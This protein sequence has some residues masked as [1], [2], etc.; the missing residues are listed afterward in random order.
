MPTDT[1][2]ALR[3]T[4]L[5]P[6]GSGKTCLINAYVNNTCP[7]VYTPTD[8]PQLYYRTLRTEQEDDDV[9]TTVL[10]E[11]E[12]TYSCDRNDGKDRFGRNRNANQW[13]IMKKPGGGANDPVGTGEPFA[14]L[15][16]PKE[17]TYDPFSKGRMGFILLFDINDESSLESVQ[18][19]FGLFNDRHKPK[20]G[21]NNEPIVYVVANKIDQDPLGE[22][23]QRLR[24][25]AEAWQRS[26]CQV[27]GNFPFQYMEVSALEFT[28]V[29][30]LFRGIA[31]ELLLRPELYAT[32]A[33]MKATQKEETNASWGGLSLFGGASGGSSTGGLLGGLWG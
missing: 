28:K 32:E 5:G 19:V 14:N 33:D 2:K 12:D 21:Q 31:D 23:P 25:K 20:I 26:H 18:K 30:R 1:I 15:P 16:P 27:E 7:N 6:A 13:I 24:R 11:I 10:L 4:I 29:R 3:I 9:L 8:D 22:E 17:A